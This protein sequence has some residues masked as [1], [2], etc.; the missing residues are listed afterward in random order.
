MW[1]KNMYNCSTPSN[2]KWTALIGWRQSEEEEEEKKRQ[3]ETET[4]SKFVAK[5][6]FETVELCWSPIYSFFF[7]SF[8][9]ISYP[10]M[11]KEGWELEVLVPCF[12]YFTSQITLLCSKSK[13]ECSMTSDYVYKHPPPTY[14]TAIGNL[15]WLSYSSTTIELPASKLV[16]W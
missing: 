10:F 7:H 4:R 1:F 2:S 6:E 9:E 12:P 11:P 5:S 14:A 8:K 3:Y 16:P 13:S 15:L